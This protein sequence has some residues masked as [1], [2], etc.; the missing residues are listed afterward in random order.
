MQFDPSVVLEASVVH[1][2]DLN[3]DIV[4]LGFIMISRSTAAAW[5]SPS[6]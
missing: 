6:S 2:P 4:S 5:R 1:D 3:R